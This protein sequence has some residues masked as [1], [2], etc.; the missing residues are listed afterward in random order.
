LKPNQIDPGISASGP[1][2]SGPNQPPKKRMAVNE[3][4]RIMFEYSPKKKRA[5]PIAEYSVKYP[6]TNSASASG[7]SKGARLVSA[8]IQTSQIIIA[9]KRGIKNHPCS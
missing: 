2:G 5:N 8:R 1:M 4:I 9:G 6:A 3:D 7:K